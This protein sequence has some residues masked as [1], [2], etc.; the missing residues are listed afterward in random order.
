MKLKIAITIYFAL[1]LAIGFSLAPFNQAL[2]DTG[3]VAIISF[4]S[5]PLFGATDI[6]PGDSVSKY[7]TVANQVNDNIIVTTAAVNPSDLDHLG[8]QMNL[9]IK[10]GAAVLYDDTMTAFFNAG[11]ID[12][13]QLASGQTGQFDYTVTF[14]S[15]AGNDLQGKTMA[16]DISVTAQASESVGGETYTVASSDGG[17]GGSGGMAYTFNELIISNLGANLNAQAGETSI[18]VTWTTNKPATSRVIYDLIAHPDLSLELPPNYGY[19][20]STI[21]DANKVIGHSV[22]ITGL[23]PG[24]TYYLR[25][26]SSASPEKY[27][28]EIAVTTM[29]EP[30]ITGSAEVKADNQANNN[31][32]GAAG[33]EPEVLGVKILGD[34]LTATGFNNFEFIGLLAA[35]LILIGSIV[36]LRKKYQR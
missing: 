1:T 13:G 19:A 29:G 32:P 8:D 23:T 6:L 9:T 33:L 28:G 12:L 15:G 3:H 10:K 5:S 4:E 11:N 14:N 27:G 35:L 22:I 26:L 17:G 21:L 2:A 25:P 34:E 30:P 16:F 31:Q 18:I 20:N 36:V 24:T 7:V